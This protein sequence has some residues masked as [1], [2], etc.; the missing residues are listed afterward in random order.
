M[1]YASKGFNNIVEPSSSHGSYKVSITV[2]LQ[3]VIN[4]KKGICTNRAVTSL[5]RKEYRRDSKRM[6]KWR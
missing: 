3:K 4:R 2:E 1:R 5:N 6:V